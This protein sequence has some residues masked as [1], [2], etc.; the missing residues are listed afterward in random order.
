M[1]TFVMSDIHG[2]YTAFQ[3]L[4]NKVGFD[5]E[6]D[7]LIIAGDIV[8][9]GR[10]NYEM[11]EYAAGKPK[12]VTFLM[13]N[14]DLDFIE[15]VKSL[16]AL[17]RDT[18]VKDDLR[19]LFMNRRFSSLFRLNVVD[20]YGTVEDLIM[21]DEHPVTMADFQKWADVMSKFPYYTE[22]EVKGKKYMIV[23]AGYMSRETYA[24]VRQRSEVRIYT[25]IEQFYIWAREEG[26]LYGGIPNGTVI[27]G[28]TPTI[29]ESGFYNHGK[30][31]ICEKGDRRFIDIDCGCVFREWESAANLAC[32]RLEGE[33]IFYLYD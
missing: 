2:C 5:P 28:H 25:D 19:A 13:G 21:D 16:D 4:L 27:F 7:E 14:H 15:Y 10:E 17:A 11:L 9:R 22:R 32:I 18:G 26:V 3:K 33:K 30:V 20:Y 1:S 29:A 12:S 24:D 23:H 6:K 8:D 31:F